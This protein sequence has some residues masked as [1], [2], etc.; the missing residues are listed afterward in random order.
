MKKFNGSFY[1]QS[2]ISVDQFTRSDI[3][4]LFTKTGEFKRGIENNLVFNDLKGKVMTALFYEPSSRTFG[5]FCAAA[6]RLGAGIIP[7]HGV[8][9]TS[10]VKGESLKDTINIFQNYSDVVILRHPDKGAVKKASKYA[11]IPV[12]NGG[13]GTGEHPSQ[14]LLDLYTLED[15]LGKVDGS[16]IG[17]VGDL[18]YG[19]TVHSLAKLLSLYKNITIYCIAPPVSPM[20]K[21]I[22]AK[23][24]KKGVKV[25]TAK[26]IEEVITKVDVLYMTRVQKER[27]KPE[28]YEKIKDSFKL[29]KKLA[30]K[31]K[32]KSL[33]M[34]PLPRVGE[35][36][37]DV[38]ENPRAMYLKYQMQNGMFVRMAILKLVTTK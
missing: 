11:H 13:D 36:T 9:N 7:I 18:Y 2:I 35:I 5:S 32:K 6:Y 14:A 10:V 21:E 20:P 4:L 3:E 19:R 29:T 33:I 38:D 22:V 23:A 1:N 25:K 15:K 30:N 27:M 26:T 8:S 37:E 28:I 16:I 34:H 24:T 31:M 17:M 12:I